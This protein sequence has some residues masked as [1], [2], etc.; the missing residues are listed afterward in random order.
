MSWQLVQPTRNSIKSCIPKPERCFHQLWGRWCQRAA[1]EPKMLPS[2]GESGWRKQPLHLMLQQSVEE[3]AWLP[4]PVDQ[5]E[6]E[7]WKLEMKSRHWITTKTSGSAWSS[8]RRHAAREAHTSLGLMEQPAHQLGLCVCVAPGYLDLLH[9]PLCLLVVNE[10][11]K[12][13]ARILY[14]P[15]R[16]HHNWGPS[17]NLLL[18]DHRV[19]II[20]RFI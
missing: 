12:V 6:T 5:R 7:K 4:E 13:S 9:T 1:V 18:T 20:T 11:L 17:H 10:A 15:H 3:A 14:Y 16:E 2:V 19:S 8:R